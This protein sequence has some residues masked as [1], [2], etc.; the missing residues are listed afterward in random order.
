MKFLTKL[1]EAIQAKQLDADSAFKNLVERVANGEEPKDTESI[2]EAAGRTV[3]DLEQAV[4]LRHKRQEAV[5]KIAAGDQARA[6]QRQLQE[7]RDDAIAEMDEA[8]QKH[9]AL[10]EEMDKEESKLRLT[11]SAAQDAQRFLLETADL[12]DEEQALRGEQTAIDDELRQIEWDTGSA[13]RLSDEMLKQKQQRAEELRARRQEVIS[14]MNRID[15]QK[16][17]VA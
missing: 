6:E 14:A 2:L 5:A 9:R 15:E 11:L 10:L 7:K 4:E 8:I 16:M 3:D 17:Q 1:R 13:V 12:T